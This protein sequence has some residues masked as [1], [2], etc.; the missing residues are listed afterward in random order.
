[1]PTTMT[2]FTLGISSYTGALAHLDREF[3]KIKILEVE[4]NP[5][6][7]NWFAIL[8]PIISFNYFFFPP[9]RFHDF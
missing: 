9:S 6:M 3:K 4:K 8:V 1:M 5:E 2:S 7:G